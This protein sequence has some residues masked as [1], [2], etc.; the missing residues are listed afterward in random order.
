VD[1]GT[2]VIH[3]RM[4]LVSDRMY[5]HVSFVGR[6]VSYI[7]MGDVFD[8]TDHGILGHQNEASHRVCI[9][10]SSDIVMVVNR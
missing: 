4:L 10:T 5:V 6:Q 8:P 1:L 7:C 9:S 2:Y 3:H